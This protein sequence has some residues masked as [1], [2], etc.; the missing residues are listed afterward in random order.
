MARSA[1]ALSLTLLVVCLAATTAVAR[2][3]GS[4]AIRTLGPEPLSVTSIEPSEGP[5]ATATTVKIKGTG[6]VEPAT[7]T[8]GSPATEV[9][10]V[11]ENEITAKT[12]PHAAGP[13]EVV[14]KDSGGTSTGGPSFTYREP[15]SVTSIEPSEGPAATATTVKIKGTGFVEPATVTIGSPATEVVV[16]SEN[17]ITAKTAPHAAGPQEVV[18]KDSGGTSTGGP[19]FTYVAL[20]PQPPPAPTVTSISPS[21]GPEAGGTSVTVTGSNFAGATAVRF[22]ATPATSFKVSSAS[23]IVAT[24]PAGK[25]KVDVT[26]TTVGGASA[27]GTA[28]AFTYIAPPPPPPAATCTMKPIYLT[29]ERKRKGKSRPKIAAGQLRVTVNCTDRAS[30]SLAGRLTMLVGKKP[31]HG[32]QHKRGFSLGPNTASI[33]KGVG[34]VIPLKLPLNA[35]VALVAK[36]KESVRITLSAT[37]AGGSTH[38]AVSI[39]QLRV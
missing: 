32:K 36:G 12:A 25:G 30:V 26:V 16:V 28:D 6:F 31:K 5:A 34:S 37:S 14:V 2:P 39:K 20:T 21:E 35:V 33:A 22:G 38:N 4:A 10:V 27:N 11:S 18:V 3:L 19:S 13:Q 7:V 17:E 8:I 1:V 24:S 15:L 23:S 29:I 9:V